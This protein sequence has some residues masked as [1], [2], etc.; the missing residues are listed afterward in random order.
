MAIT[1]EQGHEGG[2]T[3]RESRLVA[4][5]IDGLGRWVFA[6]TA[7]LI[8]FSVRY[9]LNLDLPIGFPYITFLPAVIITTFVAGLSPGI[10]TAVAGGLTAWY[11]FM[12]PYGSFALNGN[13]A[14]ALGFYIFIVVIDIAIIHIMSRA[15]HRLAEE[16]RRSAELARSREFMF[17]ELQHRVSN[18]LQVV[19][20]MM[21]MQK[22]QIN[23]QDAMKIVDE[24]IRRLQ[25]VSKIQRALHNPHGQRI[26]LQDFLNGMVPDVIEAAGGPPGIAYDVRADRGADDIVLNSTQ[27]VPVGLIAAELI[28]NC[29][30]HG[31]E[32]RDRGHIE[33]RIGRTDDAL[34]ALD[35]IDD[36]HGLDDDF[37]LA[38]SRSLGMQIARAFAMQLGGVL[39]LD[40]DGGTH[41]R[42]VFP[43]AQ[44][45]EDAWSEPQGIS[46]A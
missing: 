40:G 25:L 11:F 33:I 30:E 13:S 29:V 7:F 44:A 24:A 15:L 17:S 23:D 28:A 21:Q 12:A 42:L 35:I 46:S 4:M 10:V 6:A 2:L 5:E 27:S 20:S 37:D 43:E 9:A 1:M 22:R 38:K 18:N 26:P 41:A 16:R 39:T 34:I 31:F 3:P 8:A 14:L 32:G 36:G 45:E 19:A